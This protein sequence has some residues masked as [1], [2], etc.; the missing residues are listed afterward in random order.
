MVALRKEHLDMPLNAGGMSHW[1]EERRRESEDSGEDS[2]SSLAEATESCWQAPQGQCTRG[3]RP[4]MQ[5][6]LDF[7]WPSW[8]TR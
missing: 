7:V 8:L 4:E 6:A 5:K 3:G 1:Q 2:S